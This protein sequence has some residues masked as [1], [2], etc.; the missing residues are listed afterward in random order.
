V[1]PTNPYTTTDVTSVEQIRDVDSFKHY[2]ELYTCKHFRNRVLRL[3][4]LCIDSGIDAILIITGMDARH[5]SEM[6][7]LLNWLVWGYSGS[8]IFGN[9]AG[10]TF[11]DS[12]FVVGKDSLQVYTNQAGYQTLQI[13]TTL[14]SNCSTYVLDPEDEQNQE[15]LEVLKI[16]KFYEFV[17]DKPT[18]GMAVQKP[19]PMSK[20]DEKRVVETWPLIQAYGLDCKFLGS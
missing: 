1:P 3:Q 5:D 20:Y 13:L 6:R 18:V 7:S 8:D 19:D 16:G 17:H 12:F 10:F 4:Q 11:D 15:K 2:N 9:D 14:V